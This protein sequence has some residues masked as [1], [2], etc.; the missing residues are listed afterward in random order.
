MNDATLLHRQIH[1]DFVQA[2]T[3][4]SQVFRLTPKDK[5]RLSVYDGDQITA[6][7][8]WR[9]YTSELGY[10]SCGVMAVSVG[11]CKALGLSVESDPARYPEHAVI[12][13]EGLRGS[14]LKRKSDALTVAADN[15]GWQYRAGESVA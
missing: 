6:D 7:E 9:H 10:P 14:A 13:F 5:G 4:T 1:P 2:G 15:R 8:A 12:I 3:I 11:E